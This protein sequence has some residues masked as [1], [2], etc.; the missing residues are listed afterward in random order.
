VGTVGFPWNVGLK[1]FIERHFKGKVLCFI[2]SLNAGKKIEDT[3]VIALDEIDSFLNE[4][5]F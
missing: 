1:N 4:K 2:A 5:R 3:P